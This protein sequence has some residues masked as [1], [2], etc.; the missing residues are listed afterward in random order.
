MFDVY[1]CK[2]IYICSMIGSCIQRL[3]GIYMWYLN[4]MSTLSKFLKGLQANSKKDSQKPLRS[5]IHKKTS[6][7][8]TKK[9]FFTQLNTFY[10]PNSQTSKIPTRLLSGLLSTAHRQFGVWQ[11]RAALP[12]ELPWLPP[13]R[14]RPPGTTKNTTQGSLITW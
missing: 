3:V 5:G 4:R 13:M 6:T 14:D 8:N 10:Y 1:L 11:P 7:F 2:Y 9:D 12:L